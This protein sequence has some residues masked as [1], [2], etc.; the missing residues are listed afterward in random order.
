MTDSMIL[1]DAQEVIG[2]RWEPEQ[3]PARARTL[4]LARDALDFIRATGQWYPF[5]DFRRNGAAS[6][7]PASGEEG[8]PELREEL[9]RTERFFRQLLD[10]PL[11]AE[12]KVPIKVILDALSFISTTRQ[13]AAF[14][15]FIES[16]ETNAPPYV[17]ASFA[18][19]DEAEAWLKNHPS[20]PCS[21]DILIDDSYHHVVYERETNFRR[22]PWNRDLQH[23]L[24]WL[25]QAEPP[26]TDVSFAT[27]Q[28]AEDWL[29]A[30]PRPARRTWVRIAGEFYLAAYYPNIQ[31]RALFP[32]S[33]VAS[34]VPEP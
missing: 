20:P 9:G 24:G 6:A 5:D 12:E 11:A 33:L 23:Y 29:K 13:H 28:E 22:L 18:T 31:H 3:T 16:V 21:G 14:A 25:K 32:L 2:R 27:R 1:S 17:L 19:R 15:D 30:Q 26:V 7:S 10:D 34:D 8:F 4:G